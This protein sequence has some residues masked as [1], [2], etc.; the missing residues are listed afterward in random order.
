MARESSLSNKEVCEYIK[1]G[2]TFERRAVI[3]LRGLYDAYSTHLKD[4][5]IF[6]SARTEYMDIC[7]VKAH[8]KVG[9]YSST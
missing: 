7:K 2:H 6:T 4:L 3:A 5:E 1:S 9:S 8:P